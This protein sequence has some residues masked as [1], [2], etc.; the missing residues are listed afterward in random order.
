MATWLSCVKM[1]WKA[2]Q[3]KS[4]ISIKSKVPTPSGRNQWLSCCQV[5]TTRNCHIRRG[6][7]RNPRGLRNPL[8][9]H[10]GIFWSVASLLL[11]LPSCATLPSINKKRAQSG[12]NPY[13]KHIGTVLLICDGLMVNETRGNKLLCARTR[14]SFRKILYRK[15]NQAGG[16]P[17]LDSLNETSSSSPVAYHS[18]NRK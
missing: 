15:I 17:L 10:P 13:S 2:T 7:N 1:S 16:V 5:T 3:R 18:S 12:S 14:M 11:K 6:R 9:P 4:I 8:T